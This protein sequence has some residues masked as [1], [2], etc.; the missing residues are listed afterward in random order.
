MDR[1]WLHD[2]LMVDFLEETY[3]VHGNTLSWLDGSWNAWN[4]PLKWMMT[5]GTPHFWK[6]ME[7]L[8][9]KAMVGW[10]FPMT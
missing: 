2:F 8:I 9:L 6:H 5:G 3:E 4:M 7:T 1:L 10:A